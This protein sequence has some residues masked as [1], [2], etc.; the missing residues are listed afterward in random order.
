MET[1]TKNN[2]FYRQIFKLVLPIVVQN[3][4]SAA[5]SSADVIYIGGITG[6]PVCECTFY[7]IL[8][9]RDR[10]YDAERPVL[11]ERGYESNS[12]DRRDS[13]SVFDGDRGGFRLFCDACSGCDDASV[14]E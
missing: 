9:F 11:W 12:V 3:L 8:W 13:P 1:V 10:R 6:I 5:V 4:L 14:Y 2:S 7:G